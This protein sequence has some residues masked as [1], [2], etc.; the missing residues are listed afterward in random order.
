MQSP[1]KKILVYDLETGGLSSKYNSI[2]EFAG[3]VVD[4]DSL[5][6]VDEFS[7]MMK[8]RLDLTNKDR[9]PLKEAKS[10]FKMLKIKDPETGLN[11]LHYN[12]QQITLKNLEPL[13]DDIEEM[14][15]YLEEFGDIIEYDKLIEMEAREDLGAITKL[16][17]DKCYNPQALEVTHIPRT[18]LESEGIDYSEAVSKIKDLFVKHKVGNSK[19]IL[20]GHNIKNFDNPFIERMFESVGEDFSKHINDSQ[21]MDTLEWARLKWPELP[22][23]SLGVC[24]NEVGLTLKEAHRAL[25]DTIANA[26]FL[27][28]MLKSLRGEGSQK[29]SY[30]RRKYNFNF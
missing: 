10:L 23:Y 4:L 6:I 3:V 26:Q 24:A 15:V 14:Y 29:S 18:L 27:I 1:Y 9:E 16:Y 13:S 8:P 12:G 11:I 25:P 17:F 5:E 7:V 2:T 19:P 20:A 21:M 22:S 30:K 28:K